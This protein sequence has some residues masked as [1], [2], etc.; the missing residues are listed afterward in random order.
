MM[1]VIQEEK[2]RIPALTVFTGASFHGK[3][4]YIKEKRKS[5]SNSQSNYCSLFFVNVNNFKL[6]LFDTS[7]S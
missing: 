7:N 1:T 4:R 6:L 2:K 5:Q 3:I